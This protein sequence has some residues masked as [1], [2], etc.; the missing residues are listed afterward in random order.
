MGEFIA[1]DVARVLIAGNLT[2]G[3]TPAIVAIRRDVSAQPIQATDPTHPPCGVRLVAGD[4]GDSIEIP[5]SV[6]E[7]VWALVE[8][9]HPEAHTAPESLAAV[10]T[11]N[12]E[13]YAPD[14]RNERA[15]YAR[16]ADGF[17][18]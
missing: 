13:G 11:L 7:S 2:Q 1:S 3:F 12:D 4:K 9:L 10:V 16:T 18:A 5:M 15:E 8:T 17:M 6:A 14:R